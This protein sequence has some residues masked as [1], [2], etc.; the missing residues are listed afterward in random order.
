MHCL[1]RLEFMKSVKKK[2]SIMEDGFG[3]NEGNIGAGLGNPR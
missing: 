2:P 3:V 1:H